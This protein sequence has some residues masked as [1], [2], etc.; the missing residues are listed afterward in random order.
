MPDTAGHPAA[1][2]TTEGETA[3]R[4][5]LKLAAFAAG[6][7]LV[8]GGALGVGAAVGSPTPAVTAENDGMPGMDDMG[9]SGT[10]MAPMPGH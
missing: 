3:M 6:I 2:T 4:T 8:F 1:P 9:G 7:A 5:P 10:P